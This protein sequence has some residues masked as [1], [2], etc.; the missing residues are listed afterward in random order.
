MSADD[1]TLDKIRR[2]W[3]ASSQA[4]AWQE[5]PSA[6]RERVL[7][8]LEESAREIRETDQQLAADLTTA[9]DVLDSAGNPALLDLLRQAQDD[10]QELLT[11]F[12]IGQ[13][14]TR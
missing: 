10:I 4:L 5:I 1:Q 9:V 13:S 3:V 6:R 2:R 12:T 8:E 11:R 14:S 7:A